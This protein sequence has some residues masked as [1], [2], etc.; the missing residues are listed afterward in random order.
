MTATKD[1][2]KKRPKQRAKAVAAAT[3]ESEG[4]L[5]VGTGSPPPAESVGDRRLQRH[6]LPPSV[7]GRVVAKQIQELAECCESLPARQRLRSLARLIADR[8]KNVR[9]LSF[10]E[11]AIGECLEQSNHM[12]AV[13]DEWLLAE[14]AVWSLAWLARARR[15]GG[16][17]GGLLEQAVQ[18]AAAAATVMAT[19]D[20]TPAAFVLTLA[21]LF[22]D[23]EACRMTEADVTSALEEEIARLVSSDGSLGLNGSAS[24]ISRICR[25]ARCRRI[26]I[27][28]GSVPW[29]HPTEE[30]FTACLSQGLRLLGNDGRMLVG[31]GRL[32]QVFTQPLLEAASNCMKG[33]G[34]RTARALVAGTTRKVAAKRLLD[35]SHDDQEAA[36]AILR[37]G[38][39]PDSLR[40]QVEYRDAIPRLELA[41]G[42][43]LLFDGDWQWD[44]T[45]DGERLP[46]DGPWETNCLVA[47]RDAIV[48]EIKAPLAGGLQFERS[49]TL[50][51]IDRVVL[52]ADAV[53]R[54]DGRPPAGELRLTAT[55][56][57]ANGLELSPADETREV[58]L[59]DTV[60]RCLAMPLGLPEWQMSGRGGFVPT[61]AGLVIEQYGQGRMFAPVWL[62]CDPR[63][64]GEQVT[65]RQLTVADTR[66]NL[67]PSMAAGHRVQVGLDQWLLYRALDAPRNRTLLGCNVACEFL[68]G[69][70]T[71][72]G[73]VQRAVE[74]E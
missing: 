29:D 31:V 55:L 46:A 35:C 27:E 30:R 21:R 37:S 44:V 10:V 6:R 72:D 50:L 43:R 19:R 25:W 22:C 24:V 45:C 16:S 4:E 65:W 53:T 42:D 57:V 73:T 3:G 67:P 5:P 20:T 61:P 51:T 71:P 7:K 49:V 2:T 14:G 62:D 66:I 41:V 32:P 39:I 8:P 54:R 74:I 18:R 26:G 1:S 36:V 17:A 69:R 15:A 33:R 63:R 34:Q 47:K 60:M 40:V 58:Y 56:P 9:D 59:Y 13:R 68:V 48:F 38:W 23:I 28:S 11:A 64:L 52:L 12:A 70:V